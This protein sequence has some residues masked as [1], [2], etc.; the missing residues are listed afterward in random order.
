MPLA[1]IYA[2]QG[3]E[4]E[5]ANTQKLL[6]RWFWS[7]IFG[8]IY[9]GTVETQYTRDLEQVTEWT[10]GGVAPIMI[11][12]A[13]FIP[14]RLLSLRT[15]NSAAYKGLYALQMKSGAKDWRTDNP[16]VF[17]TWNQ[18]NIDIHHIF[19]KRWC[20]K[21]ANPPIP[22]R[23]YNS[24]I[25]KTPIDAKTNKMIGGNA[26]SRYLPRLEREA[27][28]P[29]TLNQVLKSHWLT[30]DLLYADK[31]PDCFI[32]RGEEMLKLI[33]EAMGRPM[34]DGREVFLNA[35][36]DAGYTD[37]FDDEVDV[38]EFDP[39]GERAYEN[40]VDIAAD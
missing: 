6:Q 22:P 23:L 37:D 8:E 1:A 35:L 5:T 10:R 33:G 12:E 31:F 3:S 27:I 21:D 32:A 4:L 15:R 19:P 40:E 24:V 38:I 20:E 28:S 25:N 9:G 7:G 36:Q 17:D 26:P 16:L 18:V 39:I 30:P 34:P 11:N 13:N 29:D 2:D 14:E